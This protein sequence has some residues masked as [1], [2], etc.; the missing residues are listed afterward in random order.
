MSEENKP[1]ILESLDVSPFQIGDTKYDNR[2]ERDPGKQ[3][4]LVESMRARGILVRLMVV[5]EGDHYRVVDGQ[6]R[7]NAA[8]ALNMASVPVDVIAADDAD[9][10]L[11]GIIANNVRQDNSA[12]EIMQASLKLVQEDKLGPGAIAHQLGVSE[13]YVKDLIAISGLPTPLH[14]ALHMGTLGVPAAKQLLRLGSVEEQLIVGRDFAERHTSGPQAESIINSYIIYK[15][16][17]KSLPPQEAVNLA[18][19][20]PLFP[21]ELCGENKPTRGSTGKVYC[22]DCWRELMFLWEQQRHAR[23][24]E[25]EQHAAHNASEHQ[26]EQEQPQTE[27]SYHLELPTQ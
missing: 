11:T 10:M 8:K 19:M 16:R 13:G 1:R 14:E 26:E 6:S 22:G 17:Q 4:R 21:C 20:D 23:E 7:L 18:T 27:V 3:A 25:Q 5:R 24:K 15:E 12:Y 9:A 2:V